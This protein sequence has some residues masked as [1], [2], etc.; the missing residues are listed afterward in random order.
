[1]NASYGEELETASKTLLLASRTSGEVVKMLTCFS[2]RTVFIM[3]TEEENYSV[4]I[5]H[6]KTHMIVEKVVLKYGKKKKKEVNEWLVLC[7]LLSLGQVNT[8]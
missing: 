6:R 5:V 8:H 4:S 3:Y 1:M 2:T 7:N